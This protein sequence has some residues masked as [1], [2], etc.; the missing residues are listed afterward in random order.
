MRK[1]LWSYLDE[2]NI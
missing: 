2:H 1:R